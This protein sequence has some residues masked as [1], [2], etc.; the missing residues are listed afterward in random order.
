MTRILFNLYNQAS[1]K[2]DSSYE[3][4]YEYNSKFSII[5]I[6]ICLTSVRIQ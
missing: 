5:L 1:K 4:K 6:D 3:R 2:T